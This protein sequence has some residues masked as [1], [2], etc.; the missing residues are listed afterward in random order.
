MLAGT[1]YIFAHSDHEVPVNGAELQASKVKADA[2]IAE[3]QAWILAQQDNGSFSPFEQWQL[4][5]TLISLSAVL[6]GAGGRRPSDP[7]VQRS[8]AY[9]PTHVQPDGGIYNPDEGLREA[10]IHLS[11]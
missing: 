11:H 9:I 6:S 1:N 7:R 10:V 4:G 8:L 3:G 2:A 5:I